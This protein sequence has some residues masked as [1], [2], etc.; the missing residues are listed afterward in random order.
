[1]A[2]E[3]GRKDIL[4]IAKLSM[5][6]IDEENIEKLSRDFNNIV[7]MVDKL[8]TLNSDDNLEIK[9]QGLYNV[10]R[11]DEIEASFKRDDILANAPEKKAG[12]FFV[13]KIVE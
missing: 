8:G 2:V 4:H 6:E 5:L 1:M 11:E 7:E 9:A 3:I 13:P 10:F 12:C